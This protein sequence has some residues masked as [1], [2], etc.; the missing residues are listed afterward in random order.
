MIDRG[1]LL[2]VLADRAPADW[3]MFERSIERGRFAAAK[4]TARSERM[5]RI[6]LVVYVDG[7]RGRGSARVVG[8]G[9]RDD[10]GELVAQAIELARASAGPAWASAPASA[11]ARVTL[12]DE[13]LR[14]YELGDAARAL[15]AAI[16][17]RA[18]VTI[19]PELELARESVDVIARTGLTASWVA[20]L[21]E[22]DALIVAHDRS[23]TVQRR[24]RTLRG[25]EIDGVVAE[26]ARDLELI[27]RARTPAAG[28]C[29]LVLR[30]DAMVH[31]GLGVWAAF[32]AQADAV[33]ERQG[34]SRYREG[35]AI[36]R[37]GE[38]SAEHILEPLAM[39][40]DG[41]LPFGTLSSPLG[42][43]GEAVRKFALVERGAAAGL[44]L[45]PREAALRRREPNGG[46]RNLVVASGSWSGTADAAR[47]IDVRRVRELHIDRYT[48]EATLEIALALEQ[49]GDHPITGG[50]L[51]LD[52]IDALA[53]ARRSPTR[54]RTGAY[55]GPSDI[56]IDRAELV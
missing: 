7:D 6:E 28:P 35:H 46:V 19:A 38:Q 25:L 31:G 23:V 53:F 44:G 10:A 37:R 39:W 17:S 33:V 15:L 52:L 47:T 3:V 14:G 13:T 56:L 32:A 54:M 24:A 40:S 27:A 43:E 50:T 48:G 30:G 4:A 21:C 20:T 16:P 55:E 11:P 34:L 9:D 2:R 36:A 26:A 42:D 1:E 22:L 29:A 5:R 12:E 51:R 18:G 8:D 49:P 45:A 41:A